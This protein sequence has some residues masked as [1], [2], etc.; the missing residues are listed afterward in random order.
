MDSQ[1][2]NGDK[3]HCL[4]PGHDISPDALLAHATERLA[5]YKIPRTIYIVDHLPRNSSGKLLRHSL[6][7][8]LKIFI[9]PQIDGNI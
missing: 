5:R 1:I 9:D 4:H 3:Y 2:P 8:L 6:P 7:D